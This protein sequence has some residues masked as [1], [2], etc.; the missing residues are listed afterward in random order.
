MKGFD[1]IATA[2]VSSEIATMAYHH[3][4][5]RVGGSATASAIMECIV[6]AATPMLSGLFNGATT[7]ERLLF[8]LVMTGAC[9]TIKDNGGDN[10]NLEISVTPDTL[11]EAFNTYT[12]LTGKD[13]KPHL[14]MPMLDFA[15]ERVLN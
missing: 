4:E 13:I 6:A 2:D 3:A 15:A 9:A 1:P 11:N 8:V 5:K 12:R 14:P 7:Q 10:Y